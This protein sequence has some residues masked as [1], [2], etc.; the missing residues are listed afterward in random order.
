[1]K[2]AKKLTYW[3]TY[4][5][6]CFYSKI[7]RLIKGL[8][9]KCYKERRREMC[10]ETCNWRLVYN[11]IRRWKPVERYNN[12]S[13]EFL[14]SKEGAN[15]RDCRWGR[16]DR[17]EES[18]QEAVCWPQGPV[19]SEDFRSLRPY[20]KP[21]PQFGMHSSGLLELRLNQGTTSYYQ[22]TPN[23]GEAWGSG[24]DWERLF[25][26]LQA[27]CS[28]HPGPP[29][30]L[31]SGR[32]AIKIGPGPWCLNERDAWFWTREPF[33][34]L[35]PDGGRPKINFQVLRLCGLSVPFDC[36]NSLFVVQ[37]TRVVQIV[38]L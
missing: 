22:Q 10:R 6:N 12:I 8:W 33:L 26:E 17:V 24:W 4:I 11:R 25:K 1:M 38:S 9:I 27:P 29:A 37:I 5:S 16:Q 34:E 31:T 23:V 13:A 18:A 32:E 30:A 3:S 20:P 7:G 19:W 28:P 36:H 35:H 14:G 15:W 21:S 2:D